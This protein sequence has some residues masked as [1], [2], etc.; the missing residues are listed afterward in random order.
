MEG[1]N[2]STFFD[3][4][5][6]LPAVNENVIQFFS[7]D[8]S[9]YM[10]EQTKSFRE[11]HG[12][13]QRCYNNLVKMGINR[14]TNIGFNIRNSYYF[15]VCDYALILLGARTI[16]HSRND[17][18]ELLKERINK[19]RIDYLISENDVPEVAGMCEVIE[20]HHLL[21][22]GAPEVEVKPY[23]WKDRDVSIVFSS[24]TS[25]RPK[26]LGVSELGSIETGKN[27]FKFMNFT[28]SDKFMIYLPLAS[29]QQ[30]FLMWSC[31]IKGADIVLVD[32]RTLFQGL[33]TFK[34]TILIAPPNFYFNLYRMNTGSLLKR[35]IRSIL[36]YNKKNKLL[37]VIARFYTYKPLYEALGGNTRYLIT[38]MAPIDIKILKH[39]EQ[40]YLD[41]YQI[42]GQTEIGMIAGNVVGDNKLGTVGK[43]IIPL[44]L[45]KEDNEIITNSDFPTIL[46][47]FLE[48]NRRVELGKQIPTGDL[49]YI[50]GD[51]YLT[52]RGRK[53]ETIILKSGIKIDPVLIE[54]R[55]K[56]RINIDEVVI[57]KSDDRDMKT[58][59]NVVLLVKSLNSSIKIDAI[60]EIILNDPE[61]KQSSEQV[62]VFTY[63]IKKEEKGII[64]TENNKLSRVR[65]IDLLKKNYHEF[66]L[67]R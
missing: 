12:D 18:L 56:A 43:P 52:I 22:P 26:A 25:G 30:R 53:N 10:T 40:A 32:D 17:P 34:P 54:N 48:D 21:A 13:I 23:A 7:L 58:G 16:L 14:D 6:K 37:R 51:G 35:F 9:P 39:F 4:F 15:F 60:K 33:R 27:F 38:G 66:R 64:Y 28:S 3:I 42:Y 55:I 45:S 11:M 59:L 67:I 31:L 1:T 65:T 63:K 46:S 29:Y 44:H 20:L 61:L 57:F 49:G 24:G 47:Y 50:D 5:V 41:I 36:P 19:F 62:S 2:I 8:R